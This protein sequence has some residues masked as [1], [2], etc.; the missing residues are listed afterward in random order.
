MQCRHKTII[1]CYWLCKLTLDNE[2]Q[3]CISFI[4]E[5][6]LY[7]HD[8]ATHGGLHSPM[9]EYT[10]TMVSELEILGVS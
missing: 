2:I 7:I 9:V 5:P 4:K 8:F 1:Y 6:R 10:Y 3:V